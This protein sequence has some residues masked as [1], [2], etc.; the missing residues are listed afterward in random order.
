MFMGLIFSL[1]LLKL[2]LAILSLRKVSTHRVVF[3]S[4]FIDF[5][6]CS[7]RSLKT[8]S[9]A[10]VTSMHRVDSVF[11]F[12]FPSSMRVARYI[13]ASTADRFG[14][15]PICRRSRRLYFSAMCARQVAMIF[16]EILPRQLTSEIGL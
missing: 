11:L 7:R 15:P 10:S 4:S 2:R 5:M 14:L 9:K 8:L 1:S 13:A 6:V 16:S 3:W 12:L